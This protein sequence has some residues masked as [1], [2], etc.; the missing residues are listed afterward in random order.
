MVNFRYDSFSTSVLYRCKLV[1]VP[2][3]AACTDVW[4]LNSYIKWK[5]VLIIFNISD[6]TFYKYSSPESKQ[7]KPTEDEIELKWNS[8][9][10]SAQQQNLLHIQR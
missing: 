4:E 1:Q 5:F 3:Q 7:T 2:V 10:G 8:S 9:E 6:K